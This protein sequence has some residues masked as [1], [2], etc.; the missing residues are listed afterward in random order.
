MDSLEIAKPVVVQRQSSA[1]IHPIIMAGGGDETLW[2]LS[3]TSIPKALLAV[4]SERTL[5]QET[6]LRH[7]V[8]LDFAAPV[9]ICGDAHR[10][11]VDRQLRDVGIRPQAILLEPQARG[12]APALV[13]VALWL[14]LRNPDALMLVQPGDQFVSDPAIFREQLAAAGPAAQAGRFV[15][16]GVRPARP[17]KAR[18]YIHAGGISAESAPVRVARHYAETLD[19]PAP[20]TRIAEGS[21]YWNTGIFLL[22]ARAYVDELSR[23]H[24]AMVAACEHALRLGKEEAAFFR[25]DAEAYGRVLPASIESAAMER[26]DRSSMV[27]L[28]AGWSDTGS[29][30]ALREG[31]KTDEDGNVLRGDVVVERITNSYIR[32]EDGLVAAIGVDNVTVVVT[33]DAV[34]VA[35]PDSAQEL[36]SM[37]SALRIRDRSDAEKNDTGH[38]PWGRYRTVD[39]GD[40]FRV[41]RITVDPG[42]RLSLQ[43]HLHRAEHWIVVRGTALVECGPERSLL[44][45]NESIHIPIGTEH[46][47]E[48]PGKLPLELIEIQSGTY[49][50]EDDILRVAD[51]YGRA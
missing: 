14:L 42:G 40:R 46:R 28:D 24:P 27:V 16:L 31:G 21:L 48:N 41:K 43:R 47:L 23:I 18:R 17:D 7:P 26:N 15:A 10:F 50:G 12:T 6:A 13:A 9:L 1:Q 45:E 4:F 5:L 35:G 36:E 39:R 8:G 49:L 25:L 37:I 22:S 3:G 2:P 34:L 51:D 32:S 20:G 30:R 44:T 38:R 29:W 19:L 11:V 33:D